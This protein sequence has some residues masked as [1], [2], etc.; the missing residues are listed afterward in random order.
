MTLPVHR[1]QLAFLICIELFFCSYLAVTSCRRK[2]GGEPAQPAKSGAMPMRDIN[3]VLRDHDEELMAI[4]GVV[5]VYVGVMA[6][7]KTPCLKVMAA[8]KTPE[9]DR[10]VP[11]ILEGYPVVVEESG[12]IRPMRGK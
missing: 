10:K 11:K 6:D 7:E 12:I 5:G 8:R 9:L 2:S 4:P 1:C 3:D